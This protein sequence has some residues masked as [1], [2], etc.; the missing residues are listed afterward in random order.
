MLTEGSSVLPH[1]WHPYMKYI[2]SPSAC[3]ATEIGIRKVLCQSG[4]QGSESGLVRQA[5]AL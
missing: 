5:S 4:P 3:Q 1:S 2:I